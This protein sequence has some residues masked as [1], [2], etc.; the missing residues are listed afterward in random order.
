MQG[1]QAVAQPVQG[2][3]QGVAQG[4]QAAFYS[5]QQPALQQ[6]FAMVDTDRSGAISAQELQ[7]ALAQGGLNYSLKMIASIIRSQVPQG[8][9]QLD[10]HMFCRVQQMLTR[11]QQVF[12]QHDTSRANALDLERVY[13]ALTQLGHTLD[14]QPGGA[15]Y[16]LCQ[17]FD[18]DLRGTISLDSFVAMVVTLDNAK[19][20]FGRFGNPTVPMNFDQFVWAA[21]QI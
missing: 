18:F 17:S 15:F 7:R 8:P 20:V 5:A 19:S 3:A 1:A 16:M 11:I 10:F 21:A 4:G 6:W 12:S 14:K 9:A 2:M 13:A